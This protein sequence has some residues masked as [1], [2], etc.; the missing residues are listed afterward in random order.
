MTL[1]VSTG[2]VEVIP[3]ALGSPLAILGGFAADP[4]RKATATVRPLYARCVVLWDSGSP[5]VVVS[6]E[7]LALSRYVDRELRRRIGALGVAD[8]DL[9]VAAT[10]TH[11][12]PA[13]DDRLDPVISY[14]CGQSDVEDI[15]DYTERLVEA[16]ASLVGGVLSGPQ[17]A[18][19]LTY[20]EGS[21]SFSRNRAGLPYVLTRV[22]ALTARDVSGVPL[23]ILYGYAAHPV[24]A[25]PQTYWD[26]DYPGEASRLLEVTYPAATALFLLGCAGDQNP[27]QIGSDTCVQTYGRQVAT[28][29][30]GVVAQGGALVTGP[31]GSVLT[32]DLPLPLDVTPTAANLAAVRSNY[33]T[34]LTSTAD[35]AHRLHAA[36]S[37]QHVDANTFPTSVPSAVQRWRF[38]GLQLLALGGEVVSGYDVWAHNQ[39][40]GNLWVVAYCSATSCYVPSDALLAHP[41]YEAG[42]DADF[43]G[44]AG[45][46]MTYYNWPAHFRAGSG[47]VEST[48][49]GEIS[50]QLS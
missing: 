2:R 28:A 27:A 14:G 23:A 6:V 39:F 9:I 10:H 45:G 31:I 38:G 36:R 34:R 8:S 35:V 26:S 20:G 49:L 37:I 40:G 19:T 1:A 12:G 16:V 4:P 17:H 33:L 7:A 15:R 11:N 42:F 30:Q 48:L 46:S 41:G 3:P 50:R 43:S 5:N 21:A 44:I 22:P 32:H 29:V 18:C 24:A 25:G 13:L 47:G